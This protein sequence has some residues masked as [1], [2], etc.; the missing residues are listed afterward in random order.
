[1]IAKNTDPDFEKS[2]A[3]SDYDAYADGLRRELV[4]QVSSSHIQGSHV[5]ET[6][7]VL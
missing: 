5:G 4:W 2:K 6:L 1:M 7:F 3:K